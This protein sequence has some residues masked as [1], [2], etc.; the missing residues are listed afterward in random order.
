MQFKSSQDVSKPLSMAYI[1]LYNLA[2]GHPSLPS[3]RYCLPHILGS[4]H[5]GLHEFLLTHLTL[6]PSILLPLLIGT[7]SLGHLALSPHQLPNSS[8]LSRLCSGISCCWK[9]LGALEQG[10]LSRISAP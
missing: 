7:P 6:H 9:L 2:P 4:W 3:S 5:I 1:A 8:N 10:W